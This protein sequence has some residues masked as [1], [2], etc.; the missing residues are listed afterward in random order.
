MFI[1]GEKFA[2]TLD[3]EDSECMHSFSSTPPVGVHSKDWYGRS[4][5][6]PIKV[7]LNLEMIRNTAVERRTLSQVLN[8][9]EM[10]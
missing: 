7:I 10:S 3:L 2:I 8:C 6:P 4:F 5:S 9:I 1:A